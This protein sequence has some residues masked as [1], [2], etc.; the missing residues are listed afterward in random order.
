[1]MHEPPFFADESYFEIFKVTLVREKVRF[2][3]KY[4]DFIILPSNQREGYTIE[5]DE[6]FELN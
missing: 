2:S 5:S 3:K 6:V 4:S 1:M